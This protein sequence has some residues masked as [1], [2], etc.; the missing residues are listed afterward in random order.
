MDLMFLVLMEHFHTH[1]DGSSLN[2]SHYL[3]TLLA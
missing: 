1:K 3:L 2:E